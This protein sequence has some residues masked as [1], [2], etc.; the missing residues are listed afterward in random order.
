MAISLASQPNSNSLV[1][2]YR[3]VRFVAIANQAPTSSSPSSACPVIMA[4]VYFNDKYYASISVTDY[5]TIAAWIFVFHLYEFDIQDKLQEYINSKIARLSIMSGDMENMLNEIFSVKVRVD[6]RESYVDTNGFTDFYGTPPIQGTKN[7]IPVSGT[8]TIS[9][10]T[11]YAI[12][13]TLT[14]E[15]NQDLGAHLGYYK[16]STQV[17]YA[18]SHRPNYI[19]AEAKKIGGGKYFVSQFDNDFM[20]VFSNT[21]T[22]GGSWFASLSLKYKDGTTGSSAIVALPATSTTA[23]T[24]KVYCFNAGVVNLK[25]IFG[26]AINWDNVV[27]YT[28]TIGA[29]FATYMQQKYYLDQG[30]YWQTERKRI[31]FLNNLGTYDAINFEHAT[32]VNKTESGS[33]QSSLP[34]SLDSKIYSGSNR[35]QVK[36]NDLIIAQCNKYS[37]EDMPWIKELLGSPRAYL[38]WDGTQGQGERDILIPIVIEDSEIQ[39]LQYTDRF[40]YMIIIKY[41][42]SNERINLR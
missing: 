29:P 20:F 14:H 11:F 2:A 39:T 15:D 25:K 12:N 33:W 28:V 23:A 35:S 26:T 24:Y 27:E 37:E 7:T 3:P 32:E 17:P 10:N 4:D 9:S 42:M 40:E 21:I 6:F 5:T 38:Q 19:T 34:A 16:L 30:L 8:G 13:G 22:A 36:Q 41:R 1:A 18:L 31:F